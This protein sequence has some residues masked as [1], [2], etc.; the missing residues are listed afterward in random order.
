MTSMQGG[1]EKFSKDEK[2][3]KQYTATPVQTVGEW[4]KKEA[5]KQKRARQ[6][7]VE[8]GLPFEM[9]T[10]SDD[11]GV[12]HTCVWCGKELLSQVLLE[13]HEEEHFND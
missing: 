7:I 12:E 9:V 3:Q 5:L 8:A 4:K 2:Q 1:Y 10:P 13:M 6:V 11:A